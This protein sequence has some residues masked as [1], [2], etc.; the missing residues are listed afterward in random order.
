[1][2]NDRLLPYLS[3]KII[4]INKSVASVRATFNGKFR[5]L[6]VTLNGNASFS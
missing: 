1:M 6:T 4:I 5:Q 3:K 2:K